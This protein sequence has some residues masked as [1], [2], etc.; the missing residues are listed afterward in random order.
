VLTFSLL[1]PA[2]LAKAETTTPPKPKISADS[3]ILINL[4]NGDVLYQKN[5]DKKHPTASLAKVMNLTIVSEMLKKG[6]LKKTD[7]IKVSNKAWQTGG[8]RMFLEAGTEYPLEE[9]FKGMAIV[10]GNDAAVAMAEHISGDTDSFVKLMND[11]ANELGMKNTHYRS[12]NGFPEHGENDIST[13]RDQATLASYYI[14]NFPENLNIHKTKEYTTKTRL[15]PIQQ[16][17]SNPLL[18]EYQGADGLK[19]GYVDGHYNIIATAKRNGFRLLTVVLKAPTA[20]DR[21]VDTENLLNYGFA[22]YKV[23]NNG[24]V[25]DV[26]GQM[27]VYKSKGTR[28]VDVVSKENVDVLINIKD[29]KNVVVSDKLPDYVTGG[30][31]KGEVIGQRIVKVNGKEYKFDLAIANDLPKPSLIQHLF[32]NIAILFN[33]I[34]NILIG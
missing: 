33:R 20:E 34:L 19:T 5:V 24:H 9:I 11:K 26:I 15:N 12:V 4:D 28:H 13:A 21:R 22:Q 8:S 7:S 23:V 32:D 31:K 25:G 3:A 10:S 6:T 18:G 30:M 27:R 17:N 2:G 16:F 29:E 1:L 14:K